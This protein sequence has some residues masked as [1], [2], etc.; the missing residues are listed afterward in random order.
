MRPSERASRIRFSG[1]GFGAMASAS[2]RPCGSPL[3]SHARALF[4]PEDP[5]AGAAEVFDR[6]VDRGVVLLGGVGHLHED[7]LA[8]GR[9]RLVA[10]LLPHAP[11]DAPPDVPEALRP[12]RP[13]LRVLVA[14]ADEADVEP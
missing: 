9:G 5:A 10:G 6:E 14:D 4:P 1:Y 2:L 13:A 7:Q 8:G 11:P 12:Q 3:L